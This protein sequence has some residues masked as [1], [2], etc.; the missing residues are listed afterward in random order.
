[1]TIHCCQ[2]QPKRIRRL[3]LD[4]PHDERTEFNL[5][6][7]TTVVVTQIESFV[8]HPSEDSGGSP[9]IR[10]YIGTLKYSDRVSDISSEPILRLISDDRSMFFLRWICTTSTETR[11]DQH[12]VPGITETTFVRH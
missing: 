8:L 5:C 6:L 1:M 10:Y 9:I 3:V 7:S 11:L 12:S 4:E 2:G